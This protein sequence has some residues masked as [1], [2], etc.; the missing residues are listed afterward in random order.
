MTDS[1]ASSAAAAVGGA[2]GNADSAEAEAAAK[3]AKAKI[4]GKNWPAIVLCAREL[5]H[6][7]L[8]LPILI[9]I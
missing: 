1:G 8:N 2:A 3:A 7:I 6:T 5:G 4:L 9:A